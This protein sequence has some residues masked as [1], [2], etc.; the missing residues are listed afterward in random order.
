MKSNNFIERSLVTGLTFLKDS[1]YA[2]ETASAGGWLQSLDPRVKTVSFL[3]FILQALFTANI[4]SLFYL[5]LF[6]LCL[7]VLSKINL[8]FFFKRTWFFI[9][10]FSLGIALPAIFIPGEALYSWQVWGVK[11]MVSRQGLGAAAIFVMRVVTC[12]SWVVLLNLT[13]RHLELLKVLVIFKIPQVFIMILGMCYRYV[14]LFT[15]I[16]QDTYLAIKSRIGGGVEYQRGQDIA[17]WNIS[18]LWNRSLNLSEEVY[19]A[20]LAR[21]YHG[22]ALAWNDFK[23]KTRDYWWM[24][25]IVLIIWII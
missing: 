7:A 4:L 19:K 22:E 11:L 5:Y 1:L 6:C 10:L 12:V 23:I 14:H 15:G 17:A 16:I 21:G 2:D 18:A 20:M 8:I 3:V 25:S 24:L 9:P 13:T